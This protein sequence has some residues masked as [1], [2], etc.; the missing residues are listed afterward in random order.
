MRMSRDPLDL[1]IAA[2][3]KSCKGC[4]HQF[5]QQAFGEIITV[6]TKVRADGKRHNHGKRCKDYRGA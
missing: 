2:E 6:C 3:S 5:S 1:L 4:V